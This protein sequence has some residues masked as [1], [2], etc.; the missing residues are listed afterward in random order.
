VANGA[1]DI[2]I[3]RVFERDRHVRHV[4]RDAQHLAG[5][6]HD[7]LAFEMK[8]ER[9]F[10]NVGDL[11]ALMMVF[12]HHRA[13]GQEDLGDHGFVA[14][15]DLAPDGGAQNFFFHLVPGVMFHV[16]PLYNA[17]NVK[18]LRELP[19]NRRL[20]LSFLL[21]AGSLRAADAHV[22]K[23]AGPPPE[24]WQRDRVADLAS[25]RKAVMEQLG[26]KAILI[27]YAAE[28]RNYAGDVDWPYRQENDFFYLTGIPQPGSTLVL[29]PGAENPRNSL[30]AA[31]QSRAGELD[32][33]HPDG[34]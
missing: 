29:L 25:R 22:W 19:M 23:T 31:V 18:A 5:G 32:R 34:R 28:P 12:R 2:E 33:A 9:A 11:F 10:Q 14:G 21:A 7:G 6:N 4:R 24:S 26:D 27:L 13:F 20:F 1:E 16:Q 17:Y 30:H 3:E 8:F 15:N